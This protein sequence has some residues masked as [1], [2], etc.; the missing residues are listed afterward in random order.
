MESEIKSRCQF[1]MLQ[2]SKVFIIPAADDQK[3]SRGRYLPGYG[4]CAKFVIYP[5]GRISNILILVK[6]FIII[7]DF[8]VCHSRLCFLILLGYHY[9]EFKPDINSNVLLYN[10]L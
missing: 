4:I 9:L 5:A 1:P 6:I 3:L 10:V 7:D 2:E 8:L